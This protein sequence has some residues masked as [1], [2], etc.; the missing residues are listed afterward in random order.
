MSDTYPVGSEA[1]ALAPL[2]VIDPNGVWL[3]DDATALLRLSPTCLRRAARTGALRV[4]RRG[5]R[6][7]VL[8]E[9]LLDWLRAGCATKRIRRPARNPAD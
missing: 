4:S 6:Y 2:A 8:G 1:P 5:G 7:Y 9:W 3:I